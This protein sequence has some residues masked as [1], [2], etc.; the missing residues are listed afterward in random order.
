MPRADLFPLVAEA[1]KRTIERHAD[2]WLLAALTDYSFEEG[3]RNDDLEH[4]LRA[5]DEAA[6]D[7]AASAKIRAGINSVLREELSVGEGVCSVDRNQS[8]SPDLWVRRTHGRSAAIEV[9]LIYDLTYKKYYWAT[10]DDG[11]KL[12]ALRAREPDVE[13]Y[14]VVFFVQLPALDYPG[15]R[16]YGRDRVS[17][18]RRKQTVWGGHS[19]Q[20]SELMRLIVTP[21]AWPGTS[22]PSRVDLL[23]LVA[24]ATLDVAR[25]WYQA[26]L[27]PTT[28]WNLRPEV[29]LVD[30]AAGAA[31][32]QW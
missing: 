2:F 23:P 15:G 16:W 9:K 7:T 11:P 12:L 18:S 27:V 19:A 22:S 24:P 10:K 4:A 20:F 17:R 30:A 31:I 29:H 13:L 14:Q 32:W 28:A 3:R 21:P 1:C 5:I 6:G 26:A 25:R 8:R